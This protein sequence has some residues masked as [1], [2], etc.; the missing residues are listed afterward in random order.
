MA[1]NPNVSVTCFY[2]G[3]A[4]ADLGDGQGWTAECNQLLAINPQVADADVNRGF[5]KKEWN[6][7][8]LSGL[9]AKL[10]G[11]ATSRS[12]SGSTSSAKRPTAQPAR[13][14]PVSR[15]PTT[16]AS[17]GSIPMALPHRRSAG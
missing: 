7:L 5:A 4:K 6:D 12:L 10:H 1:I 15:P 11:L 2:R 16:V 3:V 13:I 14:Q 8:R 17:V 9:E